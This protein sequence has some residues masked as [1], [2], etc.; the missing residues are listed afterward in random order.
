MA[1]Y[2]YRFHIPVSEDTKSAVIGRITALFGLLDA[3]YPELAPRFFTARSKSKVKPYS[4]EELER[5]FARRTVQCLFSGMDEEK[6]CRITLQYMPEIN[7]CFVVSVELPYSTDMH[8]RT[9]VERYCDFYAAAAD[10]LEPENSFVWLSDYY[11]K[12]I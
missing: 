3:D 9:T 8:D 4:P 2:D 1:S 7:G 10:I 5:R 12:R 11:R 6:S